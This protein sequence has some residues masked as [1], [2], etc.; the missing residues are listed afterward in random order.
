MLHE[1][2]SLTPTSQSGSDCDGGGN[3]N[4]RNLRAR[5]QPSAPPALKI[6][7]PAP[8]LDGMG[9]FDESNII[10]GRRK[11]KAVD[12]RKLNDD[13][14]GDLTPTK[15]EKIFGDEGEGWG[16]PRKKPGKG[17]GK[18]GGKKG[19]E[20]EEDEED[21]ERDNDEGDKEDDEESRS[22]SDSN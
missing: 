2:L 12:Y 3:T 16:S 17:K 20:D 6:T 8:L 21:E 4:R 10:Q 1:Q 19:K 18:G 13:M 5:R 15:Q 7:N 22:D 9:D 11:R 14:F